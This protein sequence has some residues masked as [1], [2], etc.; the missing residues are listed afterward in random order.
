LAAQDKNKETMRKYIELVW[1]GGEFER[2]DQFL[3]PGYIGHDPVQDDMKGPQALVEQ[4]RTI[5]AAFPDVEFRVEEQVAEGDRVV[6]RWTA[7]GRH[8]RRKNIDVDMSGMSLARFEDGLIAETWVERDSSV[9]M[10]ALAPEAM[11][12]AVREWLRDLRG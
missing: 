3:T 1:N 4:M 5:H 8:R 2:V 10:Q 11:A 6:T 12:A 9:V 7:K